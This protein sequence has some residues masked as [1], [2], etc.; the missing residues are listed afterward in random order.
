[1]SLRH[2]PWRFAL[3]G[4]LGAEV[5]LVIAAFTWV[6]VYSY[7]IHPGEPAE[8]YQRYALGSSPWVAVIAGV[9]VFY[10]ICR[11]I[12]ARVPDKAGPTAIGLCGIYLLLE[13]P[14]VFL[15][16]NPLMP[17]WLPFAGYAAKGVA[18]YLGVMGSGRRESTAR[19][20]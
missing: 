16:S 8:F 5:I 4:A 12:R 7:L 2:I 3:A 13:V 14:F 17:S 9:P 6:A 18:S 11:M 20:A 1:M 19:E 10:L 15:G